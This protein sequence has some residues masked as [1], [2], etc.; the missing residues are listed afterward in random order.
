[1]KTFLK[2]T[3]I[4][5]LVILFF[6]RTDDGQRFGP[7]VIRSIFGE[8][9]GAVSETIAYEKKETV[10]VTVNAVTPA[11]TSVVPTTA[12][13]VP[14]AAAPAAPAVPSGPVVPAGLS[15]PVTV[16]GADGTPIT[17]R[18]L[19]LADGRRA[20]HPDQSMSAQAEAQFGGTF[21]PVKE[22]SSGLYNFLQVASTAP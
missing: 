17:G 12:A 20:R 4:T 19:M 9:A 3:G 7:M 11:P 6:C 8:V 22:A 2:Y 14:P 5:A 18:W 13:P 21:R 15:N 16:Q 10:P 1:M